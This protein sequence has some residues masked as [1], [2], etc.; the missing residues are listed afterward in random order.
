MARGRKKT[1]T[2]PCT[3]VNA[4]K[5]IAPGEPVTLDAAEADDLLDRF[6]GAEVVSKASKAKTDESD[7]SGGETGGDAG[8]GDGDSQNAGEGQSGAAGETGANTGS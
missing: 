6:Q 2:M 4:G 5:T 7:G 3:V 8:G 1:I